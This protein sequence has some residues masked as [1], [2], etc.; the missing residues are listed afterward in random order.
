MAQ[1]CGQ[2][3]AI[4]HTDSAE[5]KH[6]DSAEITPIDFLRPISENEES[7][8]P[9]PD[10]KPNAYRKLAS[11]QLKGSFRISINELLI[12]RAAN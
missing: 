10:R 5:I 1:L 6:T 8:P 4:K 9:R 7:S 3:S 2:K 12:E 11:R